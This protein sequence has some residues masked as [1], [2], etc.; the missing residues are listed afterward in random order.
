MAAAAA[1]A[2][3]A[4]EELD[5]PAVV[6]RVINQQIKDLIKQ[7]QGKLGGT[8]QERNEEIKNIV[9]TLEDI[10]GQIRNVETVFSDN[11][12][13]IIQDPRTQN[14]AAVKNGTYRNATNPDYRDTTGNNIGNFINNANYV[15]DVAGNVSLSHDAESININSIDDIP[16]V[17]TLSTV[18]EEIDLTDVNIQTVQKRLINCQYLEILY[19]VK[20]EEL[21][22]T[23]AF[24]LTL[25]DKYQ[26]A[27]KLLLFILK[28]LL[29]FQCPVQSPPGTPHEPVPPKIK[30]PNVIIKNIKDLLKDQ[31][32]V[33]DIIGKMKT[34]LYE[35]VNT[36]ALRS[37]QV[38]IPPSSKNLRDTKPAGL[39][40]QVNPNPPP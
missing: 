17:Q 25:Y 4:P 22:K 11:A 1:A 35:D 24:L 39:D 34:K 10:N 7:I 6:F 37:L 29:D 12:V 31:K 3:G 14:Y 33:Q 13:K 8:N 20:H 28:N 30:L 9:L 27:I 19:L 32:Q 38:P 21:M 23:F 16:A 26:Y 15:T 2:Q 18:G 40:N 36:S 5:N